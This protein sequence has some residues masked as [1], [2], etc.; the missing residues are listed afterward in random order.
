MHMSRLI[1]SV[2][3]AAVVAAGCALSMAAPAS[4]IECSNGIYSLPCGA[5]LANQNW[6]GSLGLDFTVNSNVV[7]TALG[8]FYDN[9]DNITV[10]IYQ[11]DQNNDPGNLVVQATFAATTGPYTFQSLESPITLTPGYYQVAAW[12]YGNGPGNYNTGNC[13][14]PSSSTTCPKLGFNTL[15]NELGFGLPYY[16]NGTGFATILDDIWAFSGPYAPYHYYGGPNFDAFAAAA[17]LPATWTMLIAGFIGLGY[18]AYRGS[19]KS[20]AAIAAA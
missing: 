5:P 1:S 11:T 13:S 10:A 15:N 19:K 8:A 9:G 20:A 4:A 3:L 6:A 14:D 16:S 18:F 17:P 12:G 2:A 7:V